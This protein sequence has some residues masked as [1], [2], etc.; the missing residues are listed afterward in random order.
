MKTHFIKTS[1]KEVNFT[2]ANLSGAIFEQSDLLNTLFNYTDLTGANFLT[3]YNYD[4]DPELNTM[5]RSVFPAQGL[6][7]LLTKHQIKIV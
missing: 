5:K 4:I 2:Q 1:L 3:A 7:A 6:H